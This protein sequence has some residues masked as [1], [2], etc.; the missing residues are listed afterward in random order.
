MLFIKHIIITCIL[1]FTIGF[2]NAQKKPEN[3]PF[4]VFYKS[5]ALKTKGQ[6]KNK[7]RIGVWKDFYKSGVL[8]RLYSYKE[9]KANFDSKRFFE[10][11]NI[12]SENIHINGKKHYR[13][14]YREGVLFYDEAND[15]G[16][17]KDFYK[18]GTLKIERPIVNNELSGIC[19]HFYD[20][21]EKEW[22]VSYFEGY[23]QG[24]YKQFYKNGQLKLEGEYKLDVRQGKE[25]RYLENGML[26]LKGEYVKGKPHGKWV[27]YNKEGAI[28]EKLKFSKKGLVSKSSMSFEEVPVPEGLVYKTPIHPECKT[29]LGTNKLKKCLSTAITKFF[30]KK[31]DESLTIKY[32]F[33]GR[34]K[35]RVSFKIDTQGEVV[36]VKARTPDSVLRDEV[37]RVMK[38][39]PKMVPGQL[40]G[41]NID[42]PY[43]LPVI[44]S[45]Q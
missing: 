20:T 31:F 26:Y 7:K 32:G 9:G 11:G 1:Y 21:G 16:Y 6:Y 33:T 45:V 12:K 39:L 15:L 28:E 5:G 18:N 24:E 17:A 42:T 25:Q 29:I 10:D 44:L 3:G 8:K 13:K 41:E 23:K 35:I 40:R 37:I 2:C 43:A 22:E 34:H 4:E 38:L 14:Y 30:V 19:K 27:V 36:Q